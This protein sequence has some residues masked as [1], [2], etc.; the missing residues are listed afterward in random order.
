[1][2]K[3]CKAPAAPVTLPYFNPFMLA[4][5]TLPDLYMQTKSPQ[6]LI[7]ALYCG[8]DATGKYDNQQTEQINANTENIAELQDSVDKISNGEYFDKYID[9]LAQ[10]IDD[11]LIAFVARLTAYVFPGL[12]WD[13]DCWRLEFTIPESWAF[14]SFK[15]VWVSED[16]SYHA[17]I[18]YFMDTTDDAFKSGKTYNEINQNGFIYR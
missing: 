18:E 11:N 13:G 15:F 8:L 10:Y 17:E 14:L 12:Y 7:D 16:F 2:D 5:P 4:N 9:G 3:D 6:Q 1:M